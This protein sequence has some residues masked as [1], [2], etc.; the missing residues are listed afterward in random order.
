MVFAHQVAHRIEE[1]LDM[2]VAVLRI[3]QPS[4]LIVGKAF[5][6]R[7]RGALR[8]PAAA[9]V[10]DLRDLPR[11][12]DRC[13]PPVSFVV[14]VARPLAVER[15]LLEQTPHRIVGEAVRRLVRIDKRGQAPQ[16]V[17]PI[18]DRL[19]E[20]I[21]AV[22]NPSGRIVLV[23]RV[24]AE[25]IGMA[26]Q[27]PFGVVVNLLDARGRLHLRKLPVLTV[28]VCR[29][30]AGRIDRCRQAPIRVVSP[31]GGLARAIGVARNLPRTIVGQL[32]DASLG[33]LDRRHEPLLVVAVLGL[34]AE[35]IDLRRQVALVVV[36]LMPDVPMR[37]GQRNH[38]LFGVVRHLDDAAIHPVMTNQIAAP[39]VGHALDAAV[40]M[41][42]LRQVVVL[43]AIH[44]LFAA[45]GVDDAE[46]VALDVVVV[47]RA[48]AQP[49]GHIDAPEI[50]MPGQADFIAAVVEPFAHAFGLRVRAVPL[51]VRPA[52]GAVRIARD[53]VMAVLVLPLVAV[54]VGRKHQVVL[55]VVGV[56]REFRN[57]IAIGVVLPRFDNARPIVVFERHLRGRQHQAKEP[58]LVVVVDDDLVALAVANE[59]QPKAIARFLEQF[60]QLMAAV[61][62][63]RTFIEPRD[64]QIGCKVVVRTPHRQQ[65]VIDAAPRRI[66]IHELRFLDI[67]P[68]R[69][70]RDP[71]RP[72]RPLVIIGIE[73]RAIG[74][75]PDDR[76]RPRNREVD[77]LDFFIAKGK[78]YRA[79]ALLRGRRHRAVQLAMFRTR[80]FGG[81]GF[82]QFIERA[83]RALLD[84]LGFARVRNTQHMVLRI[85]LAPPG[86]AVFADLNEPADLP[87]LIAA[88]TAH[89]LLHFGNAL[90]QIRRH[91]FQI[92]AVIGVDELRRFRGGVERLLAVD[93]DPI[94]NEATDAMHRLLRIVSGKARRDFACMALG[95]M[96]IA[97]DA[98]SLLAGRALEQIGERRHQFADQ[99]RAML[100]H[101]IEFALH[102]REERFDFACI[103]LIQMRHEP[104]DHGRTKHLRATFQQRFTVL[105]R[106]LANELEQR[107][108]AHAQF[109]RAKRHR[110]NADQIQ[111]QIEPVECVDRF[112]AVLDHRPDVHH[113][114]DRG[115]D[116]RQNR[117]VLR[118]RLQ[119]LDRYPAPTDSP[120]PCIQL[121]N[122]RIHILR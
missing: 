78:A 82:F 1:P 99:R 113:G 107:P 117:H 49:V 122:S 83:F 88:Q 63:E 91:D 116:I 92:V 29:R 47:L 10:F 100:E 64:R 36:L 3:D 26:A 15:D 120:Q 19:I 31:L 24:T 9:V 12:V 14:G 102:Q 110:H 80:V 27:P 53:Q 51:Q 5:L 81:R 46:G 50:R 114:I 8:E 30:V 41:D 18:R 118:N 94:D 45:V 54:A 89:T 34:V 111:A 55:C 69:I 62:G 112:V 38:L 17:V 32:L 74:A 103:A 58:A 48:L 37:V 84:D 108:R 71:A 72:E 35:R 11:L 23:A 4:A 33:I 43:V 21:D 115:K 87:D 16:P 59:P 40:A 20:R 77:V 76:H 106:F 6:A 22:R 56:T 79:P 104:I 86:H 25:R 39:V 61:Q 90:A 67:E 105:R 44:P 73:E 97:R 42:V 70:R 85:L 98:E 95:R 121:M 7:A 68:R 28:A 109:G 13:K 60:E 75:L 52:P 57:Q 2:A 101:F 96:D 93:L 119:A 66:V 65:R